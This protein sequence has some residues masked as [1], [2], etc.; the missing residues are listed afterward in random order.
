MSSPR[1]AWMTPKAVARVRDLW[2]AGVS[3]RG[4]AREIGRGCSKNAIAGLAHRMRFPPRPSP[5]MRNGVYAIEA[6]P[7]AEL[8]PHRNREWT[9]TP[10][11]PRRPVPEVVALAVPKPL[12]RAQQCTWP[13]TD[14]RP[15]RFCEAPTIRGS[16]WCEVHYRVVYY[17]RR[18]AA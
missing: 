3:L 1:A 4:I 16:S 6:S 13:L 15:W 18:E 8:K 11:P 2:D 10:G 5:I 14:G 9:Q 12:P 17:A 7:R